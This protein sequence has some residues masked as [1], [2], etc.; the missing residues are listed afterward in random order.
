MAT[1]TV[2][3]VTAVAG[4]TVT[5]VAVT[6]VAVAAVA[7]PVITVA[8]TAV[9]GFGMSVSRSGTSGAGCAAGVPRNGLEFAHTGQSTTTWR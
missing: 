6:A 5:A 4:I 9:V 3:T 7:L 2:A 8:V 1:V